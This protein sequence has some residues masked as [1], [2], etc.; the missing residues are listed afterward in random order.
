MHAVEVAGLQPR[1]A[2]RKESEVAF[3]HFGRNGAPSF[4]G[5]VVKIA[6]PDHPGDRFLLSG[7][8]AR[9][10]N[11]LH[12]PIN[13]LEGLRRHWITVLPDEEPSSD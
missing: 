11:D 8:Y 3:A 4:A 5:R 1:L 9:F 12:S 10:I 7:A 6:H 13:F 2:S